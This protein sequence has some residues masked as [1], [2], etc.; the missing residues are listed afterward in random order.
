MTDSTINNM[1][2]NFTHEIA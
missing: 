1:T 2:S